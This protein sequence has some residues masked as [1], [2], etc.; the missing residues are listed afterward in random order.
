MSETYFQKGEIIP[1]VISINSI[2]SS[3][4]RTCDKNF[5][6]N[7]EFHPFWEFVFVTK[8]CVGVSGDDRVYKL[9][10]NS[11]IFHKPMEF[12]KIW[13]LENENSNFFVM[14]FYASGT[15]LKKLENLVVSLNDI[16]KSKIMNLLEFLKQNFKVTDDGNLFVSSPTV[17]PEIFQSVTNLMEAFF[18]SILT[19]P[20]PK[21]VHRDSSEEI[22]LYSEILQCLIK[23]VYSN[24]TLDDIASICA[25]SKSQIKRCF[26]K[27][28]EIG[29]HKYFIKLKIAEA[30]DLFY[31]GMSVGE[32][33]E[34]LSFSSPN[35]FCMAFKREVGL[36][37]SEFKKTI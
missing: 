22:Q 4:E 37:P 17:S 2:C 21:I 19:Q 26:S 32:V 25:T 11:I 31:K 28:S 14:S 9:P 13:A 18:L 35:Y 10:E 1:P 30:I 15:H 7:G 27:I 8:G 16:Q 12:H 3:F 34:K 36:S 6:F 24:L 33:S 29:I 5:Y 23:N 20:S